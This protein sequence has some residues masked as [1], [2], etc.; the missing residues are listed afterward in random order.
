M[1]YSSLGQR[2]K[3]EADALVNAILV[4]IAGLCFGILIVLLLWPTSF[5]PDYRS[6]HELGAASKIE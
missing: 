1:A 6:R 2:K 5:S 3:A 4:A